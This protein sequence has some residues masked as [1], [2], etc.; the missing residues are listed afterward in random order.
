MSPRVSWRKIVKPTEFELAAHKAGFDKGLRRLPSTPPMD[1]W[2]RRMAYER[3]YDE[4]RAQATIARE[5]QK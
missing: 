5:K 2:Q 3:G 1:N 4:G